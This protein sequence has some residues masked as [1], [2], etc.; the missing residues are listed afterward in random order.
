MP[1]K[2]NKY[3]EK[4]IA[5]AEEEFIDRFASLLVEQ[6]KSEEELKDNV[7]SKST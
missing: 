2:K 3:T 1:N 7:I 6:I 5:E 4:E